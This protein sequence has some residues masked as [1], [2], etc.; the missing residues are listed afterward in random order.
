MTILPLT[1]IMKDLVFFSIRKSFKSCVALSFQ[2]RLDRDFVSQ[3][4]PVVGGKYI[5]SVGIDE[6]VSSLLLQLEIDKDSRIKRAKDLIMVFGFLV[7]NK[8][9]FLPKGLKRV[10]FLLSG[11]NL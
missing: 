2:P 10:Y 5:D 6:S 1:S 4:E 8:T 9:L 11:F 7:A 3:V